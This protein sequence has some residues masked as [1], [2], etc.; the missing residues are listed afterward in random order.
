MTKNELRQNLS[1]VV[2]DVVLGNVMGTDLD[3][4]SEESREI[5]VMALMDAIGF[6]DNGCEWPRPRTGCVF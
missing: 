4:S 1:Q 3:L 6:F 2:V 5:V